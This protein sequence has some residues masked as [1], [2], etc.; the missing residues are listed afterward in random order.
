MDILGNVLEKIKA[1][2]GYVIVKVDEPMVETIRSGQMILQFNPT[3]DMYK[4]MK[5]S[6][7]VVSAC[8]KLP[9]TPFFLKNGGFPVP[10]QRFAPDGSIYPTPYRSE[11]ITTRDQENIVRVGETIYFKYLTLLD[12]NYIGVDE[13][14]M[15]LYKCPYDQIF[16]TITS[17]EIIMANGYI[18][19]EPLWSEDFVEVEIPVLDGLVRDTGEKRKLKVQ[20]TRSGIIFDIENKP[21]ALQGTVRHKGVPIA[22]RDYGFNEGDKVLYLKGSEFKNKIEDEDYYVMKEWDVVAK[23][24]DNLM[25][26][27]GEFV[28]MK[29]E[30]PKKG[31]IQ[32]L[33]EKK[34]IRA[35]VLEIGS[36]V[37]EVDPGDYVYYNHSKSWTMNAGE[38]RGVIFCKANQIW[39]KDEG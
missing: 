8:A 38:D 12:S 22:G 34:P 24:V 7:E 31:I 23:I 35:R 36:L 2:Y 20:M 16:C 28:M 4:N 13:D 21:I 37:T 5:I 25:Y 26:P 17:G 6:A 15:K 10:M 18:L 19:V 3:Y 32:L 29:P 14:G 30:W 33:E 39:A 9:N 27:V 11:Y 1:G